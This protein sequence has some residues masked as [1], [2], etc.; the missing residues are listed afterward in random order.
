VTCASVSPL[1]FFSHLN[2]LDG[3]PLLDTI[4]P[5][6]RDFL[7]KALYTFRDDGT[8]LYN[9]V[10]SGRAKKNNK[11]TD[12]I[13]AAF[14]R[15]LAWDSPAGN[16]GYV[17]AN[18][19]DQALDDLELARKLVLA[20]PGTLKRDC[21]TLLKAIRRKDGRGEV[22]ILPARDTVG[23]HGKTASFIGFDEIH[24]YRS[25]DLFEALAPDPTRADALQWITSYD[26]VYN[27]LGVPLYDLKLLEDAVLVVQWRRPVHGP[28]LCGAA[29]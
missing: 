14:Y 15:L 26:T 1:D 4:E 29:A 25:W 28:C 2:W 13:L 17:V 22:R 24:G 11:S 9:L 12:L 18:D 3:R 21:T 19:E 8:P 23:S 10:L 20:N 5:Y 6:R 7:T 27:S 16:N